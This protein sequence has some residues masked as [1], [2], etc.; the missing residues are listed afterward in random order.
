MRQKQQ[1]R[2]V[3]LNGLGGIG[4]TQ[5]SIELARKHQL[6]FSA[7]IWLDGRSNDRLKQSIAAVASRIPKGQIPESSQTLEK[8]S[9]FNLIIKDVKNWLSIP[10][11]NA[12]L[13]I[14]DNVN[15][16]FRDPQAATSVYD[17]RDYFPQADHGSILI[18]TRLANLEH[19][20]IGL[21]VNK[22]NKKQALA[23]FQNGYGKDF[24]G[25][26]AHFYVKSLKRSIVAYK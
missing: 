22:V 9:D 3:V 21:Q 14:F 7:V 6:R 17:V 2:V 1:R 8:K 10:E 25:L 26:L 12:W 5:L 19:L 20:G 16:D 23:I 13:L 4:K 15:Q 18:T 24:E 11:N